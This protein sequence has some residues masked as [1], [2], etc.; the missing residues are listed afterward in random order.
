MKSKDTASSPF[1]R[2]ETLAKALFSVRKEELP[3]KAKKRKKK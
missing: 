1:N 2:F 3:Q